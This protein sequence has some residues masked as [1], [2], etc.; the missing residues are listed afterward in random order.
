M[1]LTPACGTVPGSPEQRRWLL[2]DFEAGWQHIAVR[3]RL[4]T[5]PWRRLPRSLRILAHA[6]P[7]QA[8]QGLRAALRE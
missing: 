7:A 5:A 3:V 6:G 4:Q 1:L 8:R 2:E